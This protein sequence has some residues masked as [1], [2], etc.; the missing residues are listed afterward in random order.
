MFQSCEDL[1]GVASEI[2][3]PERLAQELGLTLRTLRQKQL[4]AG[5][6]E[7]CERVAREIQRLEGVLAGDTS[8]IPKDAS[9]ASQEALDPAQRKRL[10]TLTSVRDKFAKAVNVAIDQK[11]VG[12]QPGSLAPALNQL[13]SILWPRVGTYVE[14]LVHNSIAPSI[15]ASLPGMLKGG[16]QFTKVSL[17]DSS[18]LLGPIIVEHDKKNGRIEMHVGLDISSELDIELTAMGMPI[19]ITQF[20]LKGDLVMLMAPPMHK[21]PFFGGVQVYFPNPPDVGLNFVGAAKVA[22]LPGLRGAVRGAIDGGVNGVC[23]LPRRIAVDLNDDDDLDIIDLSYPEPV[24]ILRFTLWSAAS[25][26]ASDI[27]FLG[28]ASSDPYVVASL[29]IKTWTSPHVSKNLNPEWGEGA[30][31]TVDFPV[32]DDCQV[33]SLKVFDYDFGTADDLIGMVKSPDVRDLVRA[34]T[35]KQPLQLMKE[36]G[37]SG[38]GSLTISACLLTLATEEPSQPLAVSGPS[39]AHLSAKVLNVKGLKEG[40]EYPFKVRVQL[41]K[42]EGDSLPAG[43]PSVQQAK[44]KSTG[45]SF[46]VATKKPPS[47]KLKPSKT[48]ALGGSI[49]MKTLAEATTNNSHPKEQK[50]LNE[51]FKDIAKRLYERKLTPGDMQTSWTW[52]KDRSSASLQPPISMRTRLRRRKRSSSRRTSSGPAF[53]TLSSRRWSSSCCHAE[54]LTT[55]LPLSLLSLT[56]GRR[57][58][59]RRKCRCPTCWSHRGCRW[60]DLLSQMLRVSRWLVAW[61]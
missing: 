52:V 50:D 23:V 1:G 42:S 3:R 43:M 31:L 8:S 37:E 21:P 54:R 57:S 27:S 14:D 55:L 44:K 2:N 17:G 9:S 41:V 13:L 39:E 24:G 5:G 46:D 25:L 48:V 60:R 11:G 20:H 19:G 6:D 4:P 28:T 36:D 34:G 47:A 45:A 35:G 32:H 7:A 61:N 59:P 30:G 26:V 58:W 53:G 40:S 33:L 29:G 12:L 56:S 22:N 18:P 16:V 15:N 51:A 49:K 38:G 10:N